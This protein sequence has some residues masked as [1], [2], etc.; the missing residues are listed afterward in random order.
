MYQ[1]LFF[2]LEEDLVYAVSI[3]QICIFRAPAIE[4]AGAL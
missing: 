4:D 2:H 3:L 1:H